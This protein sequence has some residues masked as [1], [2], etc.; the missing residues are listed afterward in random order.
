MRNNRTGNVYRARG[1]RVH[2]LT[3]R[4]SGIEPERD[5][6]GRRA[7]RMLSAGEREQRA[8]ERQARAESQSQVY[9]GP[10]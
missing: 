6:L 5:R 3:V 9:R 4:T 7:P 1:G 2:P 10:R 8:L